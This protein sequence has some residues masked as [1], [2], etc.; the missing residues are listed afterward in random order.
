[1]DIKPVYWLSTIICALVFPILHTQAEPF[2]IKIIDPQTK[3]GIPLVKLTTTNDRV[4]ITDSAGWIAFDEPG[5]MNREVHFRI[6]SDGYEYPADGFN[7]RGKRLITKPGDKVTIEL[8]RTQIARRLYRLTGQGQFRHTT[9]LNLPL[10]P[11]ASNLNAGVMGQDSVM[12]LKYKGKLWWFWGDTNLPHY[13]L[14]HF[15]MAGA[16]TPYP[17]PDTDINPEQ[18]IKLNYFTD[19]NGNSRPMFKTD[20]PG[21]IWSN[22]TV[23]VP[24]KSGN[25]RMVA[26]YS[27]MKNLG[28]KAAH[29]VAVLN[30]STNQFD[31]VQ[32]FPLS[33]PLTPHVHSIKLKQNDLN[34]NPAEYVVFHDPFP[35]VRTK[36]TYETYIDISNHEVFT[37]LKD[38][39]IL[40]EK[41]W[42]DKI[43]PEIVDRDKDDNPIWKWRKGNVPLTHQQEAVLARIG[44]LKPNQRYMNTIDVDSG[45]SIHLHRGSVNYNPYRK[46]W[47]MIAGRHGGENSLL[48]DIY[49]LEANQPEGPWHKAIRVA[50][51][52][53]YSF[54]NPY[55]HIEFDQK[56]GQI[57][58]FQ[59]TYTNTFS[60]TKTPTP[61]YNYNQIIYQIDLA[62]PRI[63][64]TFNP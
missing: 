53:N 27:R 39:I 19:K 32:E 1:M 54:Y 44:A 49:Y 52:H 59:G 23:V 10:P 38:G 48:G 37:C 11:H 36:A 9:K 12:T 47:I 64:K 15:G 30:D 61:G 16:T 25:M 51:H 18:G 31:V 40:P 34:N 2:G 33:Q 55:H 41:N 21:P 17:S 45:K 42:R 14:G 43:N 26:Y 7:I 56:D 57:I 29:G 50:T 46:K 22:G 63:Q 62:D 24:D 28:N 58:Y 6:E 60:A 13:P 35:H 5:L 4:Y 3:R 20:M 8:K